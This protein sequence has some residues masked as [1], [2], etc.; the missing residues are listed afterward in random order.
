MGVGTKGKK[1]GHNTPPA[2]FPANQPTNS[3]CLCHFFLKYSPGK[4]PTITRREGG[5]GDR[6]WDAP[7]Q[8]GGKK[9]RGRGRGKGQVM[10][11]GAGGGERRRVVVASGSRLILAPFLLSLSPSLA[12]PILML[13]YGLFKTLSEI[14]APPPP[15]TKSQAAAKRT[16]EA[17]PRRNPNPIVSESVAFPAE[18]GVRERGKGISSPPNDDYPGAS[19]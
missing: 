1:E 9:K 3:S 4:P 14:G 2:T 5:G 6:V 7:P 10:E 8:L 11:A 18:K 17:A 13:V 19:F 12:P 15:A 16:C